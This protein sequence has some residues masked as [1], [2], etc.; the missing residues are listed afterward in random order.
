MTN[1]G[2]IDRRTFLRVAGAG[3]LG[4]AAGT[5]PF[6]TVLEGL[7]KADAHALGASRHGG[8]IQLSTVDTPV[9]MDPADAQLYASIQVYDNIFSK[10]INVTP[11][12][13]FTPNLAHSWHQETATTWVADL[14][15]NAVF[16]N[17]DHLTAH[18]VKFSMDR[19]QTH[20]N[21]VF[22]SA[23]KS[24]EVLG[25]YRVRFHLKHPFGAFESSLAMFSEIVNP[26]AVKSSNPKLHPVGSGPYRMKEWVQNDHVTLDR[27]PKYFKH[28]KPYLDQVVFRAIGNDTVRLTDLKTNQLAWIQQVPPQEYTSIVKSSQVPSSL[29][30]PYLPYMLQLNCSKPPFNDKRVRQAIAWSIDRQEFQKL[31]WFGSAV[32]ATEGVSPP[33][34]WYTGIDPYKGGP[35]IAKAKHLLKQAGHSNLTINFANQPNVPST[36]RYAVILKSQLAK[37]GITMNIQNFA[38]AQWFEQ[39]ASGKYDITET[40]WSVSVDPAQLYFPLTYSSSPWNFPKFKSAHV[41]RL[42]EKFTYSNNQKARKSAYA[43]V[44]RAVA[45]EAP[46]IFLNN[47]IQRYFTTPTLHNAGPLPSLEIKVEDWWL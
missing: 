40:Y 33:S 23:F 10:L 32:P 42:L 22:F 45:D 41:D 46:L 5:G 18:D 4:T 47:Q 9:N 16:H 15:N 6:G 35:D 44:V 31:V 24:T 34:P 14:V 26:R 8:S 38:P 39:L 19:V 29:G 28:G 20:P 7:G 37:A 25:K 11:N 30:R 3:V 1:R 21:A 17:G 27:F 12:Y 36:T 13:T 2:G 43:E